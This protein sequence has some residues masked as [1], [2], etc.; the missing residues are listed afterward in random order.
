M[1]HMAAPT[2]AEEAGPGQRKRMISF[3][4]DLEDNILARQSEE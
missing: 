1:E 4:S 2:N 3:D